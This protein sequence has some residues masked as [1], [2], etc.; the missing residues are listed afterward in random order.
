MKLG[1]DL[2]SLDELE[3]LGP[4]FT[5]KGEKVDPY[6]FFSYHSG[7]KTVRLRV[8]VDPYDEEG[9]SYGG[10]GND[11]EATIRMALKAKAA[12]MNT[13]I[14]FHYS[15]FYTDPSRQ[16]LPKPWRGKKYKEVLLELS[17]Y[18]KKTLLALKEHEI[19]VM[20]VQIGNE[21]TH[22]MMFPFGEVGREYSEENG[23]GF[24]GQAEILK[25]ARDAV[26]E[27]YPNAK[28]I[29]HLE[30]SGYL[31][32]QEWFLSNIQ[33]YFFDFDVLGES[34]YPYWH[35]GLPHFKDTMT[36]IKEKFRKEI[37][38]VEI[39]YEYIESYPDYKKD[40][41]D[42]PESE[43]VVGDV[44]GRIP[45]PKTKQGQA[46]YIKKL[47]EVCVEIGA[48]YAFYW[49][50][51]W[52]Y[53]PHNGWATHAGERYCGYETEGDTVNVWAAYTFFDL[54]GQANPV[55]DV[56]TQDFVDSIKK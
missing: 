29:L 3:K 49:E 22:G 1:V 14:D 11:L 44:N 41:P 21:V 48:E 19:D 36:K 50:P 27:I 7:I 9:N 54:E 8:W 40:L 33:K 20:G 4:V 37:W 32:I 12:G 30:H 28:V 23:G 43:F 5:Y 31:D 18:T 2:S 53:M 56:F 39:G 24:R 45:F 51:C 55:V 10:G 17:N 26:K 6:E 38:I 52:I 47:L 15:D 35:A 16:I 46:D 13:L 25:T 34:Y 42:V